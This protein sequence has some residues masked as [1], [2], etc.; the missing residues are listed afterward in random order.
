MSLSTDRLLQIET[1]LAVNQDGLVSNLIGRIEVLESST[2]SSLIDLVV[3][4]P[5]PALA[6][7]YMLDRVSVG[8]AFIDE[9][10]IDY[11]IGASIGINKE[12]LFV[13]NSLN[14]VTVNINAETIDGLD[15]I[16]IPANTIVILKKISA[17]NWINVIGGLTVNVVDTG[18]GVDNGTAT[19]TTVTTG[20]VRGYPTPGTVILPGTSLALTS[21]P[22][23]TGPITSYDWR[24][25]SPSIGDNASSTSSTWNPTFSNP[26]QTLGFRLTMTG[27]GSVTGTPDSSYR[28]SLLNRRQP[29]TNMLA[30][31]GCGKNT[32]GGFAGQEVRVENQADFLT[33]LEG[34][35]NYI[36]LDGNALNGTAEDPTVW[37]FDKSI[38]KEFEMRTPN[39]TVDGRECPYLIFHNTNVAAQPQHT[40]PIDPLGRTNS[41]FIFA[42]NIIVHAITLRGP[43]RTAKLL[44]TGIAIDSGENIWLDHISIYGHMSDDSLTVGH[45]GSDKLAKNITLSN[46]KIG[47]DGDGSFANIT[48]LSHQPADER[49]VSI[50]SCHLT[51]R[52]RSPKAQGGRLEISNCLLEHQESRGLHLMDKFDS[53]TDPIFMLARSNVYK[54][55]KTAAN[56]SQIERNS[57]ANGI[58]YQDGKSIYEDDYTWGGTDNGQNTVFVTGLP[59]ATAGWTTLPSLLDVNDVEST[60]RANAG[61]RPNIDYTPLTGGGGGGTVAEIESWDF[62]IEVGSAAAGGTTSNISAPELSGEGYTG[63]QVHCSTGTWNAPEVT[64]MYQWSVNTGGGY[65]N[66]SGATNTS[67]TVPAIHNGAAFKCTVTNN[68][69]SEISD[70]LHHWIPTDGTVT[71]WYDPAD[72]DNIT[73]VSGKVSVV[74]D[75]GPNGHDLEQGTVA[76]QATYVDQYLEL[77]DDTYLGTT[78]SADISGFV[79]CA[80]YGTGVEATFADKTNLF[81]NSAATSTD[82]IQADNGTALWT[83]GSITMTSTTFI[84]GSSLGTLTA[85]PWPKRVDRFAFEPASAGA[86]TW[87]ILHTTVLGRAFPGKLYELVAYPNGTSAADIEKFEAYVMYKNGLTPVAGSYTSAPPNA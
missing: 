67:Y 9:A 10:T 8:V 33:A 75:S 3:T 63:Q 85:L 84:N 44:T 70:E 82:K 49:N 14:N 87:L 28:T 34:E 77:A 83:D 51:A 23:I 71:A 58:I 21:H 36:I 81:V 32:T 79:M 26:N 30:L 45:S 7:T 86:T 80:L 2:K 66:I 17:T 37:V 19:P 16:V 76:R 57:T 1:D 65:A 78:G 31:S 4:G 46:L 62:T 43:Q 6:T 54:E 56:N 11:S 42:D 50:H 68:S 69:V 48:V 5:N 38:G 20:I 40:T 53:G 64:F 39:I 52:D 47:D 22:S 59:P 41:L 24:R 55:R 12:I 73:L 15:G 29:G 18:G 13:G 27:T 25:I 61:N 72:T 60:I 35:G 74:I